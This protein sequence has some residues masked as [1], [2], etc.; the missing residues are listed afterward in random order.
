MDSIDEHETDIRIL[1]LDNESTLETFSELEY[2]V[3]D[4]LIL[5]R[6]KK[7]LGFTGGINFALDH[8]I[9]SGIN[10]RYFFLI[11]PDA[12]C[13]SNVIGGLIHLLEDSKNG[14]A[15]SPRIINTTGK[16][17]Y[18][19]ARID[20]NKGKVSTKVN[21]DTEKPED[22]YEVDAYTG[23][24][25]LLDKDKVIEAGLFNEDLFMYYD[26][27]ELCIRLKQ[28][29]YKIYYAPKYFVIHDLSYTTRKN[30]FIKTYYMTRNK[31]IVFSKSMSFYNKISFAV[32]E[33]AFHIKNRRLKDA[34]YHLKGI[35]DFAVGKKG[36]LFS[37]HTI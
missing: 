35:Y 6:S 24:A 30:T 14:A 20:F 19:G 21:V 32:H 10:F 29:G 15:I 22:I 12:T 5:L 11:N 7:N 2:I 13:Y 36:N 8:A 37:T 4:R 9:K 27:A 3:D 25:V 28:L 33:F 34:L 16:P 1:V 26:E 18:S 17:G 23:C 31:F